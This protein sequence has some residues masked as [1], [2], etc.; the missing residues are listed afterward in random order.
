MTRTARSSRWRRSMTLAAAAV[1]AAA[2][3]GASTAQAGWE[4]IDGNGNTTPAGHGSAPDQTAGNGDSA[5]VETEVDSTTPSPDEC[6]WTVRGHLLVRNPTAAGLAD[7][8]PVA[9]IQVKVSGA[10]WLGA[11]T[12][13]YNS[14][15]T[16]VTNSA[17]EFSV[18][19]TECNKRR[20]RVEAKFESDDLRVLGPTS[21]G[22][23]ELDDTLDRIYPSILD[24]RG[25]PFGGE[26]GNQ[27]H[28]AGPHRCPDLDRVPAGDRP[29]HLRR[30]PVPEPHHRPQPRHLG[31]ERIVV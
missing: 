20:V 23:Y 18:T 10:D 15:G 25:E 27:A 3:G 17:G 1:A 4:T 11:S 21:P 24:L 19:H 12:G 30:L 7:G 13:S 9:G 8:E 26:S 31:A 6:K 29:R 14:W 28:V 16:V 5:V 22:W 2:L